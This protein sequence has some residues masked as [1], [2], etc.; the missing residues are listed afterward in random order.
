[1]EWILKL[2]EVSKDFVLHTHNGARFQVL[3]E[4]S[5]ACARGE[6][7][8]IQGLPGCGKSTLLKMIH[9]GYRT[10][11]GQILIKSDLAGPDWVGSG[12]MP[13]GK[14]P[15]DIAT[16]PPG[17]L[18]D[19][20]RYTIGYV[21]QTLQII[22]GLSAIETVLEPLAERQETGTNAREKAGRILESLGLLQPLWQLPAHTLSPARRQIVN[23]AAGF[24]A[25]FPILL[26]DDPLAGADGAF[27]DRVLKHCGQALKNNTCLI[28]TCRDP[29]PFHPIAN[30]IFDMAD[31]SPFIPE[32]V[33]F[34]RT[35]G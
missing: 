14:A 3:S 22:P 25:H 33:T 31:L 4:L 21:G 18:R 6:A 30:R 28:I 9:G 5:L 20:R 15:V 7:V 16:A 13:S 32:E 24:T 29:A 35:V 19:I 27:Q 2:N 23:L 12:Q 8:V 1:M 34:T 11:S 26:L 10:E 17:Q